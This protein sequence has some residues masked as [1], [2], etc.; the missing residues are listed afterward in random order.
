MSARCVLSNPIKFPPQTRFLIF[1]R[2]PASY[3]IKEVALYVGTRKLMPQRFRGIEEQPLVA[4]ITCGTDNFPERYPPIFKHYM[5]YR[6]R[7][8]HYKFANLQA[9]LQAISPPKSGFGT[10]HGFGK[11]RN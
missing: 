9:K 10:A 6:Q 8:P 11:Y 1:V 5:W 2:G 3:L 4:I 7:Y